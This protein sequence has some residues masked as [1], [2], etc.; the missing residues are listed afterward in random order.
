MSSLINPDID[1]ISLDRRIL[2]LEDKF[3]TGG[4]G[5][6]GG[7]TP[8]ITGAID[9]D[10]Y[11]DNAWTEAK[12]GMIFK[13]SIDDFQSIGSRNYPGLSIKLCGIVPKLYQFP[14]YNVLPEALFMRSEA[15]QDYTLVPETL[16][17]NKQINW[18][19]WLDFL[20]KKITAKTLL[21][22]MHVISGSSFIYSQNSLM[23]KGIPMNLKCYSDNSMELSIYQ[24]SSDE[25]I[26]AGR[27][28]GI[29]YGA[30]LYT[31]VAGTGAF[32]GRNDATGRLFCGVPLGWNT[33]VKDI[34]QLSDVFKQI[35]PKS[36][37][38]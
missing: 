11:P 8:I 1:R 16:R 13:M 2:A 37:T 9:F 33:F 5:G 12:E 31:S 25:Y 22:D 15:T 3:G 18:Q 34:S 4:S 10:Q 6:S 29:G 7:G 17:F 32:Y 38:S 27:N 36:W 28:A 14:A 24:L 26:Y 35:Y 21:L 23:G 30:M 20:N 19:P